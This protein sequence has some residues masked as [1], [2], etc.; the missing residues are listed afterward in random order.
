MPSVLI[1]KRF[2]GPPKS[3]NGGYVC[4]LFAAHINGD[5]EVT[6]LAPPPID[7][8]LDIVA[9]EQT[10][11]LRKEE[12][13]LAIG[14]GICI[15]VPR[16]PLVTFREAQDAVRR[17]PYDESRH[18]LP[19]CFVCGPTRMDGDG[20]RI[21]A[22]A[23]PPRPDRENGTL[24]APWVP[25]ANLASNDGA[26]AREFIWATLD[27]PTGFACVGAR[28][29]GMT[30]AEPILL[31]RMSARIERR[32]YPGDQCVVLAWPTGRNGRK[33]FASSALLSSGGELLAIA[34]T[35]WL[36]VDRHIQLGQ[37]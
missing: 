22:C 25:Y 29:L 15:D 13:T 2:C 5:A 32:P 36:L 26:V 7:Q 27:C 12:T 1:N 4:G 34:Q 30:G 17:S 18:P 23:L 35:T 24:A 6:L 28:H 33:L 3:A 31:G 21:I 10:V 8:P 9:R 14:R 19:T 16:V 37:R 11:E 20:L